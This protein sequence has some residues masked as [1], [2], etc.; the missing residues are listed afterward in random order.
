MVHGMDWRE[1][2]GKVGEDSDHS[3]FYSEA[4]EV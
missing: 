3:P 2:K 1:E 4:N